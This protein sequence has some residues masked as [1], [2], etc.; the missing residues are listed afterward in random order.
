MSTTP[1]RTTEPTTRAEITEALGF[2]VHRAKRE[3][4]RCGTARYPTP[5]DRRHATIDRLL[6]DL[7]RAEV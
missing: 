1:T 6:D 4:P 2:Q 3:V 7:E 5:W